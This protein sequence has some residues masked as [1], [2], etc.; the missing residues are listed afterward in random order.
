[1]IAVGFA[2]TTARAGIETGLLVHLLRSLIVA[3]AL[4]TTAGLLALP[5][6]AARRGWRPWMRPV[7]VATCVPALVLGLALLLARATA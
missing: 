3:C 7:L 6:L 4:G 2:G 1:M 5:V